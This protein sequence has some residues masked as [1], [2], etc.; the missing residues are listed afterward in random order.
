M[1]GR[2]EWRGPDTIL[3]ARNC[4]PEMLKQYGRVEAHRV[5]ECPEPERLAP[6]RAVV[7]RDA[8]DIAVPLPPWDRVVEGEICVARGWIELRPAHPGHCGSTRLETLTGS[9]KLLPPSR[10][11]AM[12]IGECCAESRKVRP[13][14]VDRPVICHGVI[15]S[16]VG[17]LAVSILSP[18]L[19]PG[20]R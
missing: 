16:V 8:H 5:L 20:T 9:A 2:I 17:E 3:V 19:R 13:R 12:K 4:P 11:T 6:R 1:G 18:C 10:E 7:G 15:D 14:H